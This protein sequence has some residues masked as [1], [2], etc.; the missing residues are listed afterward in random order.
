MERT[1]DEARAL[2]RVPGM[3]TLVRERVA[4]PGHPPLPVAYA[5][6]GRGRDLKD[7]IHDWA[8]EA[9]DV[10][11]LLRAHLDRRFPQGEPG[12]L[13]LMAPLAASELLY[14]LVALGAPLRRGILGLGK[15]LD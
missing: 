4:A 14:R 2:F 11:V 15:V 9:E 1:L 5:S 12:A 10:L 6:L 3:L 8:G 7:A 13:F